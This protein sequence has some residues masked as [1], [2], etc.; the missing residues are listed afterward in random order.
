MDLSLV[1]ARY[2][3]EPASRP[4]MIAPLAVTKPD[5]G[6]TTTSPAT[7]PEQNP[8]IVGLPRVTHS[9]AGQTSDAVAAASVVAMK[10][11]AAMPSDATALPA[12]KPYQPTQSMPVP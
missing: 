11:A 7:A 8:R 10:A 5:A 9:M 12:L 2:G 6:V 1:A 4:M 3:I